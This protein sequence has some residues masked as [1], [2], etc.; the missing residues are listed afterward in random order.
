MRQAQALAPAAGAGAAT[1][2]A[3]GRGGGVFAP[4]ITI[5]NPVVDTAA[6]LRELQAA[7]IA[8]ARTA[9]ATDLSASVDGII[10]S[11]GGA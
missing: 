11:G 10:R 1:A 6:R 7:I 4:Q 9:F 3:A 8:A 2:A 5:N